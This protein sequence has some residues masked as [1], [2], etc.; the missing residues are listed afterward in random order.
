MKKVFTIL[1]VLALSAATSF[2]QMT[3][4]AGYVHDI[5][6]SKLSNSTANKALTDGFYVEGGIQAQLGE[7]VTFNP[8]LRYTFLTSGESNS[9]AV[10][11]IGTLSGSSRLLEH[12]LSIPAMFELNLELNNGRFFMFA[13]PTLEL[14]LASTAKLSASAYDGLGA[15]ILE[16]LGL[17][18][19]AN[20]SLD[21]YKDKT[22]GRFDAL[23]G[24]GIGFQFG[25]F[26]IKAGYNYGMVDRNKTSEITLH[27]QQIYCGVAFAL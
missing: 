19:K 5:S 8:T 9:I 6:T 20:M 25:K 14:G 2:A 15:S 1:A 3:I 13:G 16:A 18:S 12:Y 4:G 17:G 24:G 21:L 10:P 7:I 11:I 27:D 22:Y 23:I 26:I